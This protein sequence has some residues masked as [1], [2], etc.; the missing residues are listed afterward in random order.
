MKAYGLRKKIML[1]LVDNHPQ[2]G[3]K[4]WWEVEMGGVDKGS[5]RQKAKREI[6]KIINRIEED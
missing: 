4:N 1:N 5:A 2:K 3:W 6:R